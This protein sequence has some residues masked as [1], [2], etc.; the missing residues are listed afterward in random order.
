MGEIIYVTSGK[1]NEDGKPLP[2]GLSIPLGSNDYFSIDITAEMAEKRIAVPVET[3]P[4]VEKKVAEKLLKIIPDEKAKPAYK[5]WKADFD[6]RQDATRMEKERE[7]MLK[8]N[9]TK[10]V[11]EAIDA[12]LKPAKKPATKGD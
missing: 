1:V 2:V 8:S 3:N 6:K 7:A 10:R 12:E 11:V 5:K 9:I 4:F